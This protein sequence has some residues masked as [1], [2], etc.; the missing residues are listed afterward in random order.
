ML[1]NTNKDD[2]TKEINN[3][4]EN[5]EKV[6]ENVD[7]YCELMKKMFLSTSGLN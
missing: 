5:I 2:I 4:L 3:L 7:I 6:K 1:E